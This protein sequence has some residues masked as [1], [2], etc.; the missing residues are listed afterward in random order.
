VSWDLSTL[1]RRDHDDLD[2]AVVAMVASATPCH[3]LVSLLDAGRLALAVHVAAETDVLDKLRRIGVPPALEQVIELVRAEHGEQVRLAAQLAA[4]TPGSEPWYTLALELRIMLL[5]HATRSEYMRWSLDDHVEP[6][7]R[8]WL[9]AEYAT[10]RM[11]AVG[12]RTRR[13]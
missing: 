1:V 3:E 7:Q 6:E 8:R 10:E 4:V 5:D 11:R 13:A 12:R 9:A 2:A